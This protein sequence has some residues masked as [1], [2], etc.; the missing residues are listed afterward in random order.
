[1]S[2]DNPLNDI[3][4][5]ILNNPNLNISNIPQDKII[6]TNQNF[7]LDLM[8]FKD[9]ILKEMKLL[10][11]SVTEKYDFTTTYIN[12]KFTKYDNKLTSYSERISEIKI[13][14]STNDDTI[15]EIKTLLDFK[16]KI[17]DSML[18]MDIKVNNMERETKNNIFRIDNILT[19]SVIYPGIIGK[20]SKFKT[21][22]KMIDYILSQLSQNL[23]YKE[24]NSFDVNQIK[25]KISTLEQNIQSIKENINK[26]IN[27]LLDKK[28]EE[29]D[30]KLASLISQYDERLTNTRAQNAEYIKEIQ[31]T[32]QQF[33]T[34]LEEFEI[35]KNRI[36]EEIKEEGRKLRE[37]SE[38]TQNIFKGYKK[39]F[40]LMKDRFTQL[41][42]FIKDVR[43]RINLGQEVKRRDY[44]H[45][46]AKIDF[47]KKQ[48]VFGDNNINIYNTKYQNDKELPDFLM[49]N[50]NNQ[51]NTGRS[52]VI[53]KEEN[54]KKTGQY[55]AENKK[56]KNINFIRRIKNKGKNTTFLLKTRNQELNL[57][58]NKTTKTDKTSYDLFED[59][60]TDKYNK[61]TIKEEKKNLILRNK[62]ERYNS[63]TKIRDFIKR[64]NTTKIGNFHIEKF[65]KSDNKNNYAINNFNEQNSTII[66]EILE[67]ANINNNIKNNENIE[68]N[69]NSS[70]NKNLNNNNKVINFKD[71]VHEINDKN[72][73]RYKI[74]NKNIP[75]EELPISFKKNI[76]NLSDKIPQNKIFNG[77]NNKDNIN[78]KNISS[79][80]ERINIIP[81]SNSDESHKIISPKS[82]FST[83]N[84]NN[85]IESKKNSKIYFTKKTTVKNLSRI[86]SAFTPKYPNINNR[87]SLKNSNSLNN[88][89]NIDSSEKNNNKTSFEE[90]KMNNTYKTN[91]INKGLMYNPYNKIKGHLSPNVKILQ[92]SV[93]HLYE[94]NK[95][96]DNLTGMINNLQ[97]YINGYDNNYVNKK[98]I[99]YEQKRLS[100]NSEYFKLKEII[101]RNNNDRKPKKNKANMVEIGFNGIK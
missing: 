34:K 57:K 21:F 35:I 66:Q 61:S 17:R 65:N 88:I 36:S 87:P 53:Y 54:N 2:E 37:E 100:K 73:N 91:I 74:L 71:I 68:G 56:T 95:E 89:N 26:E 10:K 39:E 31:E 81:N 3:N 42:E 83:I 60:E 18:T 77:L 90:D 28:L 72:K 19:D 80:S 98:D 47:S 46:S 33:K 13:N 82:K 64:S 38:Q 86:Q 69:Y 4:N 5:Q 78:I 14:I 43:F 99:Q 93:E 8:Q 85:I 24:K 16:N 96:A 25:K 58:D 29:S 20:S 22:H 1:M 50:Y 11:K 41:S 27:V 23:I 55:S 52:D 94:N 6:Q 49:N 76:I 59:N 7:K 48:K 92:H 51:N 40:N 32:V 101:N 62:K 97:K 63:D 84:D 67:D 70:S 79:L 12:E 9:E 44:Y 15:K 30:K 75:K 45:M